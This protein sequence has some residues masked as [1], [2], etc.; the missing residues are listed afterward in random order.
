MKDTN[1]KGNR[2]IAAIHLASTHDLR[3]T[4]QNIPQIALNTSEKPV[5]AAI[6]MRHRGWIQKCIASTAG[7]GIIKDSDYV[8]AIVGRC[9]K[10]YEWEI[11][12]S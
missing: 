3:S 4:T 9:Q 10:T 12:H 7:I 1:A 6:S 2:F 5:T 8:A 11:S